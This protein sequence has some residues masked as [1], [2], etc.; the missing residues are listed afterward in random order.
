MDDAFFS[1]IYSM[2]SNQ[3]NHLLL[4]AS[5]KLLE[6]SVPHS[7][8][9]KVQLVIGKS[10]KF[11]SMSSYSWLLRQKPNGL[12]PMMLFLPYSNLDDLLVEWESEMEE[13]FYLLTGLST[14]I[15]VHFYLLLFTFTLLNP[16]SSSQYKY[17]L[18]YIIFFPSSL[19]HFQNLQFLCEIVTISIFFCLTSKHVT[20]EQFQ[21][22]SFRIEFNTVGGRSYHSKIN[23]I[24]KCLNLNLNILRPAWSSATRDCEFESQFGLFLKISSMW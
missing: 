10:P 11:F 3:F 22:H 20:A 12:N 15:V 23:L 7:L 2:A 24:L 8:S 16:F 1:S 18:K 9:E 19:D 14:S 5:K 17:S 21:F 4:R 13:I 6:R